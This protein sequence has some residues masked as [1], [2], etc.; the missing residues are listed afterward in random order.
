MHI[1]HAIFCCP[2]RLHASPRCLSF[3]PLS[4]PPKGETM[5][6]AR[7]S[8]LAKAGHLTGRWNDG[9]GP[10]SVCHRG[11]SECLR[12]TTP[13]SHGKLRIPPAQ[14]Y[15][16]PGQASSC[17]LAFD[18]LSTV[19]GYDRLKPRASCGRPHKRWSSTL[20]EAPHKVTR[21]SSSLR[22]M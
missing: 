11:G 21:H 22:S 1:P 8:C 4:R 10:Q 15:H 7:P 3:R 6:Y 14:R 19:D 13:R 5:F 18:P 12:L 9:Y 20:S 17:D 16:S 2:H